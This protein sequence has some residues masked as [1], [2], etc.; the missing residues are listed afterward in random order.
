M[1]PSATQAWQAASLVEG[2]R[3][4]THQRAER[5]AL[6]ERSVVWGE[7]TPD[8]GDVE[9]SRPSWPTVLVG[10]VTAACRS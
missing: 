1:P 10:P 7:R 9:G 2:H 8:K 3:M 4:P 5:E 6:P